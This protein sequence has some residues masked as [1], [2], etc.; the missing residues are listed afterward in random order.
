LA[1]PVAIA[2]DAM[3]GDFGPSV[4]I[5]AALDYL[6]TSRHVDIILVGDEALIRSQ[7]GNIDEQLATRISIVHT[8]E[9]VGM[10][11]KASSALRN[12]QNS[13]MALAIKEVADGRAQACL[14]AGNTGALVAFSRV[15]IGMYE[16]IDRPALITEIPTES[17]HCHVLDLGANVKCNAQQLFQFA[18]M[19]GLV[20]QV[21]DALDEPRI[22]LL[23]VG[24]EI[25]KGT[26]EVRKAGEL[27]S[28]QQALNYIGFVEGD[29]I[30]TNTADVIV[31]DGYVGNV[32]L[33]TSEGLAKMI[34]ALL[35]KSFSQSLISKIVG[36]FA[37]SMIKRV[38]EQID[39]K[40]HNGASLLGLKGIVVKSH[41][42][43]DQVSFHQAID[44][45][46]REIEKNLPELIHE[47]LSLLMG[48]SPQLADA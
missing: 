14:S 2:I 30:F 35:F 4:T 45:A 7:T 6:A 21:V 48:A 29:H 31:C 1:S 11:E 44:R 38:I 34:H 13:S 24:Q 16:E 39:P 26:A 10:D 23:N 3:G 40:R 33:K 22:A 8:T 43:A 36:F 18:V 27:L 47:K 12:K 9:T 15:S 32:A 46:H 19:G 42:N 5:P 28:E 41:G 20:A 37:Q 17:G 25:G